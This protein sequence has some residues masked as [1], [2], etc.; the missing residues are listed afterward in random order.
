MGSLETANIQRKAK[1]KT[2]NKTV[3]PLQIFLLSLDL[4]KKIELAQFSS[5]CNQN[6]YIHHSTWLDYR[7]KDRGIQEGFSRVAR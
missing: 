1:S 5:N 6:E 4:A 2:D 7:G 3:S